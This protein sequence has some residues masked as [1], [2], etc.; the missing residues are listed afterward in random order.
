VLIR[1]I[2]VYLYATFHTQDRYKQLKTKITDEETHF[3][4]FNI[5]S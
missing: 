2:S 3:D 1:K 5:I 4:Y